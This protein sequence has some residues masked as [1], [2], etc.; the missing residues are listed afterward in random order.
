MAWTQVTSA[1]VGAVIQAH[2][3]T[4]I[5]IKYSVAEPTDATNSFTVDVRGVETLPAITG[6]SI[7][8]EPKENGSYSSVEITV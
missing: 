4:N 5:Q 2:G 3:T 1:G 8:A 7:W 6:L